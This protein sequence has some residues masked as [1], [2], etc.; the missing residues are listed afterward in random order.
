M[1]TPLLASFVFL[2]ACSGSKDDDGSTIPYDAD[3]DTD[4]D[5]DTD[6]DTDT[7]TD[8]DTDSDTDTD[9]TATTAQTADTGTITGGELLSLTSTLGLADKTACALDPSGEIHCWGGNYDFIATDPPAGP[10]VHLANGRSFLCALTDAGAPTCW[11]RDVN[12]ILG[13]VPAAKGWTDLDAGYDVACGIDATG[14]L[15]CFGTN[16]G[17]APGG[18]DWTQVAMGSIYGCARTSTGMSQCWPANA[19]GTLDPSLSPPSM[20]FD[21]LAAGFDHACGLSGGTIACWG[22]DNRGQV[23]GAPSGTFV[24]I[25]AGQSIS[26]AL[27]STGAATCWGDDTYRLVTDTPT[28]TGLHGLRV[29]AS[30]ACALDASDQTVCW[31]YSSFGEATPAQH[32]TWAMYAPGQQSDSSCQLRSD[33]SL[34][35]NGHDFQERLSTMPSGTGFQQ[36]R[37]AQ[38][39]ACALDS[40]DLVTCWGTDSNYMSGAPGTP[41]RELHAVSGTVCQVGTNDLVS[42]WGNNLTADLVTGA[43]T[44]PVTSMDAEGGHACAVLASGDL[45]CWGYANAVVSDAPTAGSYVDVGV[46]NNSACAIDDAGA[47][48]CWGTESFYQEEGPDLETGQVSDA[49]AAGTF[50]QVAVGRY[51]ACAIDDAGSLHC[52]GHSDYGAIEQAPTMPVAEVW[53][54]ADTTC[55]IDGAGQVH[56][57]GAN[58]QSAW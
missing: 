16:A 30:Y 6:S 18:T 51:H 9:A 43:P 26:C 36:V 42:C 38:Y 55:A 52:W 34:Q 23:S 50:V 48:A 5:A 14:A 27:D 31:G 44:A 49:P 22:G 53:V 40:S 21:A 13:T 29:Q 58:V 45:S 1:R 20:P 46:G 7:D 10:F 35:C 25:G 24:E 54:D 12:G 28:T 19:G 33:G 3:T 8:T 32:D 15:R 41:A 4:A 37:G 39:Y 11:G 17:N 56:C 47:L 2:M 57:R